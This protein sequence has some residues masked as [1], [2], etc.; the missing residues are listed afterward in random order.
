V[1]HVYSLLPLLRVACAA[2]VFLAADKYYC[3]VPDLLFFSSFMDML[4]QLSTAY[5]LLKFSSA[6][7][8]LQYLAN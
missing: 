2:L 3:G 7:T 6:L 4:G 5:L 1:D 8:L